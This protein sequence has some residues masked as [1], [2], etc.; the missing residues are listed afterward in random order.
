MAIVSPITIPM[1]DALL[2]TDSHPYCSDPECPCM[3][4]AQAIAAF[5]MGIEKAGTQPHRVAGIYRPDLPVPAWL[6]YDQTAGI[7]S[8]LPLEVC[9]CIT[10][11]DGK[12]SLCYTRAMEE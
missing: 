7:V 11:E 6:L 12:L 3:P 4:D 8:G 5:F 2:H 10:V 1:E 9:H